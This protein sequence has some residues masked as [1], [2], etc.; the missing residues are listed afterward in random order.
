HFEL[1]FLP[2]DDGFLDEDLVYRA[3]LE[4]PLDE[5]AEL[6]D[7]VGD[8]AADAAHR[9]RR[10]DDEWKLDPLLAEVADERARLFPRLPDATHRHV[11]ADFAHRVLEQLPVLRHLDR[12]N[13]RANELDA[14]F[15][16]DARVGEIHGKV[17]GRL[18]SD[19]RQDRVR[20][21][22]RDDRVEH[23]DRE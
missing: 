17:E 10:A 20:L 22:A 18:A 16:E 4:P 13:R 1:E 15:L 11:E 3:E 8:A 2:A 19:G 5:F 12:M 23:F 7:V 14:V 6:L 21:L 9:E